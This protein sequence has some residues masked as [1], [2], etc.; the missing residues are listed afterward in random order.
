MSIFNNPFKIKKENK[1]YFFNNVVRQMIIVRFINIVGFNCRFERS[2]SSCSR[3]EF[4]NIVICCSWCVYSYWIWLKN[5]VEKLKIAS[6]EG[7]CEVYGID[8]LSQTQML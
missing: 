6:F 3:S 5:L 1:P 8:S 2:I 4:E 7:E